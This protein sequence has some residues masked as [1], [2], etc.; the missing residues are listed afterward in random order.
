MPLPSRPSRWIVL[1]LA[2]AEGHSLTPVQLQKSLFLLG[3]RR[4]KAVQK[5]FY[6]FRPYDY[7]PFD[8]HVYHDADALAAEGLLVVDQSRGRSLR[9]YR[10]TEEGVAVAQ[11][12]EA[13]TPDEALNYLGEVVPW[14]QRLSFNELVRAV[15]DEYPKMRANSVF[16][17][18]SA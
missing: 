18:R 12:L 11:A 1:A 8:A 10:L 15:Y 9:E 3:E 5:P 13:E 14:A 4:A 16:Q 7:G 2:K 17:D 6:R